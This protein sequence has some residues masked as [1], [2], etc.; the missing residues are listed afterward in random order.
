MEPQNVP[1]LERQ[2]FREWL[3]YQGL[4]DQSEHTIYPIEVP[5]ESAL[6]QLFFPTKGRSSKERTENEEVKSVASNSTFAM[7]VQEP[8]D[9]EIGSE[10]VLGTCTPEF[11]PAT[12]SAD[13]RRAVQLSWGRS[14]WH[15]LHD[16]MIVHGTDQVS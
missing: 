12:A 1:E 8:E 11:T 3:F 2:C 7:H 6:S 9:E 14:D 16:L 15:H 13:N 10:E 5:K 4:I